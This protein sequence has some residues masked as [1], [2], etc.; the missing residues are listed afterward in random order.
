MCRNEAEN[1]ARARALPIGL[2]PL[3]SEDLNGTGKVEVRAT[4]HSNGRH[5]APLENV[6]GRMSLEPDITAVSWQA[7][8][9]EG[10]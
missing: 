1:H 3:H 8:T 5:D 2:Q 9:H 6:V 4:F 10:Q 7:V